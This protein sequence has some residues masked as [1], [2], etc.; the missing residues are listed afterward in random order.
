MTLLPSCLLTSLPC[1]PLCPPRSVCLLPLL[2][3]CLA[4]C[5]LLLPALTLLLLMPLTRATIL[6]VVCPVLA[7]QPTPTCSRSFPAPTVWP[8]FPS[9]CLLPL[10]LVRARGLSRAM[11]VND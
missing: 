5:P 10:C 7:S 6:P 3:A 8:L 2:P 9:L 11:A 4:P 1:R